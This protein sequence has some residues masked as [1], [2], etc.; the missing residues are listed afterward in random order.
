MVRLYSIENLGRRRMVVKK[1]MFRKEIIEKD[2]HLFEDIPETATLEE[3]KIYKEHLL[4]RLKDPENDGIRI[5]RATANTHTHRIKYGV[6]REDL[7]DK[8]IMARDLR[9]AMRWNIFLQLLTHIP[10]LSGPKYLDSVGLA[11]NNVKVLENFVE[12]VVFAQHREEAMYKLK[13]HHIG[14]ILISFDELKRNPELRKRFA[15][16]F[17]RAH[18]DLLTLKAKE[19]MEEAVDKAIAAAEKIAEMKVPYFDEFGKKQFEPVFKSPEDI[20]KIPE[21]VEFLKIVEEV[22]PKKILKEP[23]SV[24]P[25]QE[26]EKIEPE[27]PKF[28]ETKKA[29]E[30][31]L[32]KAGMPEEKVKI[33][34]P[35][36]ATVKYFEEALNA[37]DHEVYRNLG[38]VP[39]EHVKKIRNMALAKK[40][41]A[42]HIFSVWVK[43]GIRPV[44]LSEVPEQHR[45]LIERYAG[46]IYE[47]TERLAKAHV[48]GTIAGESLMNTIIAERDLADKIHE[49]TSKLLSDPSALKEILEEQRTALKVL[50]GNDPGRYMVKMDRLKEYKEVIKMHMDKTRPVIVKH[51]EKD[52]I[53]V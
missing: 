34:A 25:A 47:D 46:D 42:E 9:D 38:G 30:E 17:V 37:I 19:K 13:S 33:L 15:R 32:R 41:A 36:L 22:V 44:L 43:E 48:D 45:E 21:L 23:L 26:K 16:E 24:P 52:S 20:Y 29:V 5:H 35:R 40:L 2:Y 7:K 50:T 27:K 14:G 31:E 6:E 49:A 3:E 18:Y 4:N 11:E 12:K 10:A 39:V 28:P 8:P 53:R 1:G 51:V